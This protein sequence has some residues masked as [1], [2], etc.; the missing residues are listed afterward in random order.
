MFSGIQWKVKCLNFTDL[1]RL[2]NRYG[3]VCVAVES[4][5]K[6]AVLI[7]IVFALLNLN[8]EEA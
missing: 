5:S 3:S 8:V 1:E 4:N 2:G 6:V 7:S